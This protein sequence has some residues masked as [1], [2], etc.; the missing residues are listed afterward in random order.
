[1]YY[2]YTIEEVLSGLPDK[3]I[4]KFKRM[5]QNGEHICPSCGNLDSVFSCDILHIQSFWQQMGE[6]FLR[7]N[8]GGKQRDQCVCLDCG[9]RWVS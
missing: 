2:N 9:S 5:A 4:K 7:G 1:M 8:L 3:K 6:G